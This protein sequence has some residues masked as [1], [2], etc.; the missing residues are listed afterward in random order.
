MVKGE[1]EEAIGEFELKVQAQVTTEASTILKG[2]LTAAMPEV[3]ESVAQQSLQQI[4][5]VVRSEIHEKLS[6][7]EALVKSQV[8]EAASSTSSKS[9]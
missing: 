1:L 9:S 8:G 5:T 2:F 4:G 3:C 7:F 6:D